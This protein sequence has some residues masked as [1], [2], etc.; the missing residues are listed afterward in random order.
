MQETNV[1]L[2]KNGNRNYY[3]GNS[4]YTPDRLLLIRAYK[5]LKQLNL[6]EDR[7]Y[8]SDV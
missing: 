6:L 5:D 4:L 7:F 1:S 8:G 2:H 3:F